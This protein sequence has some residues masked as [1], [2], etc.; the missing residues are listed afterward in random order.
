MLQ[1][2]KAKQDLNYTKSSKFTLWVNGAL[3]TSEELGVVVSVF[4]KLLIF[5]NC[6]IV[7]QC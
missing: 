7:P 4:L 6:Q 2:E 1:L 5:N 3:H